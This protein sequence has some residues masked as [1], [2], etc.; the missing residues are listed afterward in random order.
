MKL[1]D[2]KIGTKILAI[3]GAFG[4]S[5]IGM[6]L[7]Q[8]ANMASAG[9]AYQTFIKS[10]DAALLSGAR[11]NQNVYAI[12]GA[13]TGLGFQTCPSQTCDF[14]VEQIK[15]ADER[16]NQRYEGLIK[17]APQYKADFEP[18]K[19]R[20]DAISNTIRT[21]QVD[22]GLKNDSATLA[23]ELVEQEKTVSALITDIR[24]AI[25]AKQKSNEAELEALSAK[26]HAQATMGLVLSIGVVVLITALASFIAFGDI[27]RSLRRITDQMSQVSK[28]ALDLRIEGQTRGDE[29]GAMAQTLEVF[30]QG[31]FEAEA[32]RK[33]AE[34][35]KVRNEE[36]RRRA[37]LKLA[38]DFEASVG[39]IVAMVSSAATEMQASAAQLS[40]TA[41]ETAAQSVAVSSAAEEAGTNVTSV[42]SAA[43]E[44]GASVSEIGR[45]VASSAQTSRAAVAQADSA[46]EVVNE[47]SE[48]AAS[49]NGIVDLIAGLAGQTNLLALNATIESAR[50]GEAGKGFAVV[51]SE[52][53]ALAGQ[54]AKATTDISARIGQIQEATSKA[55]TAF[56]TIT[57][58][59][60]NIDTTNAMISAAVEQ[61]S[62]ATQEIIQ[63]VNQASLGT[64]E[65][66]LN[67]TG[68]AQ[69]SGQTGDA[70]AQ[71]L[72][73]SGELAQQAERLRREMD[74]FLSTVRAA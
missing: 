33:D 48:V 61:Q 1:S 53:K 73:S 16:F 42:A 50:A 6:T 35:L 49:I 65:V 64:Q 24:N 15:L 14:Y 45:Q 30:R 21:R 7:W 74:Q 71:V 47:L 8:N 51:A 70:A 55:A 27:V 36:D 13:I 31:L 63:A 23:V 12:Q 38:D 58:T 46:A 43:E 39:Q 37:M 40:A 62:A 17:L 54:T 28:G 19:Q 20:F 25:D 60:Q 22:L 2:I 4:I 18:L 52:V 41:Q 34:A 69:A 10:N 9:R 59:I 32:L 56:R 29:I 44:M 68:V 66:T 57:S 72:S 11:M 3:I 26:T 67:I 5:A